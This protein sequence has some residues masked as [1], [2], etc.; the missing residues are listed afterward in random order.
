MDGCAAGI[1]CA[2]ADIGSWTRRPEVQPN[3]GRQVDKLRMVFDREMAV[4]VH[5]ATIERNPV[6]RVS[7][8]LSVDRW[9]ARAR[10]FVFNCGNALLTGHL[11]GF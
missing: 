5:V 1:S 10:R 7:R 9:A 2:W 6:A 4:V 3:G 11:E 8:A